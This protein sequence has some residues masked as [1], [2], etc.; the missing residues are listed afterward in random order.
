MQAQAAAAGI[1]AA[2][3]I[4]FVEALK[5][6]RQG[7]GGDACAS[8]LDTDLHHAAMLLGGKA[9]N[10]ACRGELDG[11]VY[12]VVHDL[13][14]KIR[15]G[16]DHQRRAAKA[17]DVDLAILDAL[18]VREDHIGHGLPQVVVFCVDGHLAGFQLGDVQ[19]VLHQAGQAAGLLGDDGQVTLVFLGRDGAVQHAVDKAL[20]GGHG[21]AQLVGDVAHELAAGVI[22]GLQAGSHIIEGGGKV[23]QL[24]TAV[25]R[26]TGGKVSATQA[27]GGLA[28]VLDGAGDALGQHPAQQAAQQQDGRGRDAEHGQHIPHITGQCRHGAGGKQVAGVTAYLNTAARGIVFAAVNAAQRA[29]FKNVVAGVHLGQHVGGDGLLGKIFAA[30][31]QQNVAVFVG[32]EQHR[33]GGSG[34]Q[35]KAVAG[36]FPGLLIIQRAGQNS[37]IFSECL[38]KFRCT[39]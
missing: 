36:V 32:H 20:D 2:G 19:H 35:V 21:R 31:V 37:A 30:G 39:V 27:A 25:H 3:T 28:D 33:A 8:V 16:A 23:G 13:M 26:G 11:V 29:G 7:F 6:K 34:E 10:A 1:H 17:L 9:D 22:D 5:H 18:L 24:H 38:A 4:L 12:D 14:H 15:V